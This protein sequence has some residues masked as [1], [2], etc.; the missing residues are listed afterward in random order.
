[1]KGKRKSYTQDVKSQA[2]RYYHMGLNAK[3]IAKLL[4][5]ESHRTVHNWASDGKW[6]EKHNVKT[7]QQKA[8]ELRNAKKTAKEIASM[9]GVDI[10]TVYKWTKKEKPEGL[11][12]A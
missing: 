1:M 7:K 3:E 5:V 2:E 8:I 12:T 11:I 10:S 9:L 4:D 6:L